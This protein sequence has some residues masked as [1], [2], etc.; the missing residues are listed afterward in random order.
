MNERQDSHEKGS[1]LTIAQLFSYIS[2]TTATSSCG[3]L[4]T[5]R[6]RYRLR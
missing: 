3:S 6:L 1:K 5:V 2:P 4:E